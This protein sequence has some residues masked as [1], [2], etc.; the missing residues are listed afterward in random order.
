M[1]HTLDTATARFVRQLPETEAAIDT[2]IARVSNLIADAVQSRLDIGVSSG[3]GQQAL[4]RMHKSL[5]ELIDASS[6]MARAHRVMLQ[7][8]VEV[9]TLDHPDCPDVV[10]P[11]GLLMQVDAA[12]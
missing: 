10:K 11:S 12:A 6:E 5:G 9:G 1:A 4:L 3:T 2:A 8:A 7:T